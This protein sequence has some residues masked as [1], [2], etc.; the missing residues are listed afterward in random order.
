MSNEHLHQL[1]LADDDL[2]CR[3]TLREFFVR[4]GFRVQVA[5]TGE[6]AL[7]LLRQFKID[8][9]VMDVHM[10]DLT[11][12]EVLR[13]LLKEMGGQAIPPTILVSS[14]GAAETLLYS[15][16]GVHL[17]FLKKPI[18]LGALRRSVKQMLFRSQWPPLPGLGNLPLGLPD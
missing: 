11:G 2:N 8:V 17:G 18:Q 14:D 12:P 7:T 5:E 13:R 4:E 16:T 1:L 6:E 10:P 15:L 3:E 9:S